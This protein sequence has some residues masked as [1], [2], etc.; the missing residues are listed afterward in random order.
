M[1]VPTIMPDVDNLPHMPT[2]MDQLV[3]SVKREE[4]DLTLEFDDCGF[5]AT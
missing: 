1:E 2:N 5:T 4:P 3:P